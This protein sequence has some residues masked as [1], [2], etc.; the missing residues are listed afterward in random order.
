[1]LF[2]VQ[3]DLQITP[4]MMDSETQYNQLKLVEAINDLGAKII[5]Y[6]HYEQ[7]THPYS[8]SYYPHNFNASSIL[9]DSLTQ[10]DIEKYK[11]L[12]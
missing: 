7:Q 11:D 5:V 6:K 1:M 10:A 4:Y 2:L 3:F 8:L 12:V 9:S